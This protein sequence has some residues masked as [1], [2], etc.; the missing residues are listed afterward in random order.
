MPRASVPQV[1]KKNAKVC[2]T[3][4]TAKLKKGKKCVPNAKKG[5]KCPPTKCDPKKQEC[6]PTNPKKKTPKKT[7]PKNTTPKKVPKKTTKPCVP[8]KGKKCKRSFGDDVA[9][10][11]NEIEAVVTELARRATMHVPMDSAKKHKWAA[12]DSVVTDQLSVCSVI[13]MWSKDSIMEAHIPPARLKTGKTWENAQPDDFYSTDV[14]LKTYLNMFSSVVGTMKPVGGH[15]LVSRTMS[16]GDRAIVTKW[17]SDNGVS[18]TLVEYTFEKEP[19]K[20]LTIMWPKDGSWPPQV[21]LTSPSVPV[22]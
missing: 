16:A 22:T 3:C 5:I 13:A 14:M 8:K 18:V 7:T 10:D 17:F 9:I 19:G 12:G 6:T 4:P 15:F 1:C 20:T 2:K 11:D 21:R